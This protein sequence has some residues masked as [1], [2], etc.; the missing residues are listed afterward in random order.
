MGELN[1][2]MLIKHADFVVHQVYS[3]EDAGEED[4]MKLVNLPAM[5]NLIRLAGIKLA[6]RKRELKVKTSN[7]IMPKHTDATVTPAVR[8]V[9]DLIFGDQMRKEADKENKP[10]SKARSTR[11]GKCDDCMKK[12]CGQCR[13]CKDMTKFGG[14]GTESHRRFFEG[15]KLYALFGQN[16]FVSSDARFIAIAI[17]NFFFIYLFPSI[18]DSDQAMQEL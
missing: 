2:E 16:R 4:D 10:N 17:Y 13:H 15:F 9:F 7:K 5:K 18:I 8:Q 3:Y 12:D 14:S 11:C 6:G 1:D